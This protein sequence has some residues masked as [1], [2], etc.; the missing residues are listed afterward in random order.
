MG[1]VCFG[2]SRQGH[3]YM[4]K[5]EDWDSVLLFPDMTWLNEKTV[6]AELTQRVE[7]HSLFK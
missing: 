5:T 3:E 7:V 2:G 1:N 6:S 4:M